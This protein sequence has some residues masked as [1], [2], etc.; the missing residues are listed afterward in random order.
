MTTAH[1]WGALALVL[2]LAAGCVSSR[3]D[4]QLPV[5]DQFGSRQAEPSRE[6]VVINPPD[7]AVSYFY[8]PAVYDTVHV[9][10]APVT[11]ARREVPVEVL[12]K[13]SFPD[14]CFELHSI[15]QARFENQLEVTVQMRKPQGAVCA[16]VVRPYRFYMLLDGSYGPGSYTLK[17]NGSARTFV[18][19]EPEDDA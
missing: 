6:I 2:L 15:D 7:T 11:A 9:R 13:G 8:Y 12:I 4:E 3:T 19:R 10:P 1:R 16:S 5:D 18:I 17:I 14:T